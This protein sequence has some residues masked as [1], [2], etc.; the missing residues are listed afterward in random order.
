[1]KNKFEIIPAIDLRNGEV[2]R[3]SQ[4]EDVRKTIYNSDAAEIAKKWIDEGAEWIHIVNLDAAFDEKNSLNQLAIESIVR[5]AGKNISLQIGGGI[6]SIKQIENVIK[7]GFSRVVLGTVVIENPLFGKEAI[8]TFGSDML[9]FGL[10]A[11]DSILMSHGWKRNSTISTFELTDS[12][13]NFG[14]KTIIYTNIKNDGMQNGV[15]WQIAKKI[16]EDYHLNV[17]ASG[18]TSTLDDI[19]QVKKANLSGI[20]IGRALYENNFTLTEAINVY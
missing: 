13:A 1:M 5:V 17:I 9:A 8:N 6:R 14:A 2:V 7:M 15:D 3:L 18:G 20:I 11:K 19:F 16:S 4:G 10:D 12:L